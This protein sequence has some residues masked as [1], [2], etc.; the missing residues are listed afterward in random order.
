VHQFGARVERPDSR[1][2]NDQARLFAQQGFK[3]AY[4]LPRAHQV[5]RVGATARQ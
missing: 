5:Y 3:P 4:P 1:H 2:Y